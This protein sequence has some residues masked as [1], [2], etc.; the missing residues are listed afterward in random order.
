MEHLAVCFT[1]LLFLC[2]VNCD[3]LMEVFTAE[4]KLGKKNRET[5]KQAVLKPQYIF[6]ASRFTTMQMDINNDIFIKTIMDFTFKG[7]A[8]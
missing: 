5:Q 3:C 6:L 8:F 7:H 2:T 1:S 4:M